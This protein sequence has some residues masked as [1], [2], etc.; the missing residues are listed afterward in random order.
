M[1]EISGPITPIE[2]VAEMLDARDWDYERVT[3]G[4]I[5]LPLTGHWRQ[6]QVCIAESPS[7][8]TLRFVCTFPLMLPKKRVNRI[9][10]LLN[11]CNESLCIG[12]LYYD[13]S[14]GHI[15][16]WY[17][18]VLPKSDLVEPAQV[19]HVLATGINTMDQYYPAFQLVAGGY[20]TPEAAV[21]TTIGPTL[22]R[23]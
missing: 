5:V 22:G 17:T 18:L 7:D 9:Y 6:Y 19:D 21:Q 15:V 4:Q 12:L 3:A 14:N 1:L 10:D 23:A 8:Q 13:H 20:E 2:T 16:W 11:R